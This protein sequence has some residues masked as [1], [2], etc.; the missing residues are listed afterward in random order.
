MRKL[1]FLTILVM[2]CSSA[3]LTIDNIKSGN[4][5]ERA[6]LVTVQEYFNDFYDTGMNSSWDNSWYKLY[7][8]RKYI[9]Y[10]QKKVRSQS[11]LQY[12]KK[13]DKD[14][15]THDF[16]NYREFNDKQFSKTIFDKILSQIDNDRPN[17]NQSSSNLEHHYKISEGKI[18][19]TFH[20]STICDSKDKYSK[21]YYLTLLSNDLSVIDHKKE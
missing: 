13:V 19:I 17:C 18:F 20:V 21:S 8:D 3:R 12:F 10:G 9:Y 15:L 11:N 14:S 1:Y 7:E 4:D 2:S 6:K 5:L 16:P